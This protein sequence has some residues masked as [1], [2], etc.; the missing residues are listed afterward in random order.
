M[1]GQANF[2]SDMISLFNQLASVGFN[3]S[4]IDIE[5]WKILEDIDLD[6]LVEL[7]HAS[8]PLCCAMPGLLK[9]FNRKDIIAACKNTAISSP[10]DADKA[11]ICMLIGYH[12]IASATNQFTALADLMLYIALLCSVDSKRSTFFV[13]I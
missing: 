7:G 1:R 6:D 3:D 4:K 5:E 13:S 11:A 8:A 10:S 2:R 9:A 12:R